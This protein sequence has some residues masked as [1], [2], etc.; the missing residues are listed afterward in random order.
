MAAVRVRRSRERRGREGPARLAAL[1][2]QLAFPAGP[3]QA[4]VPAADAPQRSLAVRN[5]RTCLVRVELARLD[6]KE[7]SP[8]EEDEGL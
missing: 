2:E 6:G 4:A 8:S 3:A 7:D 5:A 1:A